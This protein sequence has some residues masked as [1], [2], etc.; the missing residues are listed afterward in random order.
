MTPKSSF[1]RVSFTLFCHIELRYRGWMRWSRREDCS[2]QQ[3]GEAIVRTEGRSVNEAVGSRRITQPYCKPGSLSRQWPFHLHLLREILTR[4]PQDW[5]ETSP[6]QANIAVGSKTSSRPSTTFGISISFNNA[7]VV[8]TW[9]LILCTQWL[10]TSCARPCRISRHDQR[11]QKR[12]DTQREQSI[13]R[14]IRMRLMK[15]LQLPFHAR[16]FRQAPAARGWVVFKGH[17]FTNH[18]SR[19][20]QLRMIFIGCASLVSW[21][22]GGTIGRRPLPAVNPVVMMLRVVTGFTETPG[23]YICSLGITKWVGFTIRIRVCTF[24]VGN[25][26]RI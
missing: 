5:T 23:Q 15:R 24:S 17:I 4:F 14:V 21:R 18:R 13:D 1:P 22:V 11:R 2:C 25:E 20:G 19:T 7:N 12:L 16:K 9:S 8:S 6:N 10:S 26:T 3:H